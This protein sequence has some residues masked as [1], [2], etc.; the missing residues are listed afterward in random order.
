MSAHF[1]R[2]TRHEALDR[3]ADRR[4]YRELA[5]ADGHWTAGAG[6]RSFEVTDPGSGA[7]LAWVASLDAEQAAEAI[8]AAARAF[9]AW[10][11]RLPQERATH[12]AEMV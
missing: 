11:G 8:G 3:L 5:Y 6:G 10:R 9:P 1:A 4:L 7:S 12:L 2:P